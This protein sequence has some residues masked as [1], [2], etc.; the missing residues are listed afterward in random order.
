M[1]PSGS[2]LFEVMHSHG[3]WVRELRI[4]D[5]AMKAARGGERGPQVAIAAAFVGQVLEDFD[6]RGPHSVNFHDL[7]FT[8]V[9]SASPHDDVAEGGCGC[10]CKSCD[11]NIRH[12]GKRER[13]CKH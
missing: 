9:G 12:C 3:W 1:S 6:G 2:T 4:D 10:E 8:A 13:G 5:E 11:D 7:T